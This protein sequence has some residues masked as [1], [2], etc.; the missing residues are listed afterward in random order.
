MKLSAAP[1]GIRADDVAGETTA[2]VGFE[3]EG[4]GD[5]EIFGAVAIVEHAE[6]QGRSPAPQVAIERVGLFFQSPATSF[7]A[8][9]GSQAPVLI[10]AI[11][12]C[13]EEKIVALGNGGVRHR[14]ES[15]AEIPMGKAPTP[16][17]VRLQCQS[18]RG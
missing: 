16:A 13:A 12:H 1:K 6:G 2:R 9:A 15:L 11:E 18:V 5:G 17:V 4:E 7:K 8:V 14:N 3:G 10:H